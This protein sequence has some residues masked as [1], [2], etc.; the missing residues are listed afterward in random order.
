MIQYYLF[1]CNRKPELILPLIIV[2]LITSQYSVKVLKM[3]FYAG[4]LGGFHVFVT[5]II[6]INASK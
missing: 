5:V 6:E 1:S 2:F 4:M 3:N